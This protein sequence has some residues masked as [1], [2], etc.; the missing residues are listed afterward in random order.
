MGPLE[1]QLKFQALMPV[2]GP[3]AGC[4]V[5]FLI[6]PLGDP[7]GEIPLRHGDLP[8]IDLILWHRRWPPIQVLYVFSHG[9]RLPSRAGRRES[10]ILC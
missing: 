5:D 10:T 8:I 7:H 1:D 4:D 2:Q 9:V 3:V 6:G